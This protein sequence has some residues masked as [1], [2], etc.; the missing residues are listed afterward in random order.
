M[1]LPSTS[2]EIS[3]WYALVEDTLMAALGW[4]PAHTPAVHRSP[5]HTAAQ[6][7]SFVQPSS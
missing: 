6:S 3:L 1:G 2:F 4:H 7:L 5:N